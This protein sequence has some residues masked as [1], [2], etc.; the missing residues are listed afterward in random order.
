MAKRLSVKEDYFINKDSALYTYP[1]LTPPHQKES[2]PVG[3]PVIGTAAKVV[4]LTAYKVLSIELAAGLGH[5]FYDNETDYETVYFDQEIQHDFASW[6]SG[7]SMEPLYPNGSVALMKQTGFDY[8]GGGLRPH[9]E[10]ED[11]YQ[12]KSIG[13]LKGLRLE[14]INPDYDDLFAP[15]EDEPKNRRHCGRAFSSA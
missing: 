10:R 11:L 5:T 6:V 7:N 3:Q 12:E 8:D 13:R 1:L 9:L 4:S 2:R 14:S 15:Y